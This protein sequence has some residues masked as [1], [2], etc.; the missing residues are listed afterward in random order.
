MGTESGPRPEDFD[1]DGVKAAFRGLIVNEIGLSRE[2]LLSLRS[3]R[4]YQALLEVAGELGGDA[5]PKSQRDRYHALGQYISQANGNE[6]VSRNGEEFFDMVKDLDAEF[7][8]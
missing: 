6:R 1:Y 7:D 3:A 8:R 5:M 2:I 4:S